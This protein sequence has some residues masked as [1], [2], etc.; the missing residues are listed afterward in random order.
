MTYQVYS[1]HPLIATDMDCATYLVDAILNWL[2]MSPWRVNQA[3][4]LFGHTHGF[5][6]FLKV[7]LDNISKFMLAN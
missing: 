7:K 2:N 6:I 5:V 4:S 3:Y 1:S